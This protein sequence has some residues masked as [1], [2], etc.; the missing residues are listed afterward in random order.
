VNEYE[1][2]GKHFGRAGRMVDPY[3]F[4]TPSAA[5]LLDPKAPFIGHPRDLDE[6]RPAWV[7]AFPLVTVRH[8][9][10]ASRPGSEFQLAY[11]GHFYDVYRKAGPVPAGHIPYGTPESAAAV[12]SCGELRKLRGPL[13]A[14][15]RPAAVVFD[16]AA[17][18]KLPTGWKHVKGLPLAIDAGTGGSV[19]ASAPLTSDG[20]F[21][22]WLRGSAHRDLTLS[23]DGHRVGTV[24]AINTPGQWMSAGTIDL[25]AGPHTVTVS[26]PRRSL[27]PGDGQSD[28]I[29]PVALVRTGEPRLVRVASGAALCGRALDWVER[30]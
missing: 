10:A 23:V 22:V 8:S 11:R 5:Q 2:Y 19:S 21:E 30:P 17:A 9:P 3:E 24:R 7:G 29:G 13:I 18:N 27:S 12:P 15:E 25:G 28:R 26:R 16:I 20:G 14:A 1:E 6:L 4:Y